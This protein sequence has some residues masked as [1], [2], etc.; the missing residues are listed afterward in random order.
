MSLV[1]C[2]GGDE[3]ITPV[4]AH[5][6]FVVNKALVPTNNNESR[7]YGLDLNG[8]GTPDNQLGMVLGTLAG[9]GFKIQDTLDVAVN[10]GNIILLLDFQAKDLTSA[11]A[12]GIQLY[13]GD[14]TTAM[15]AP[16]NGSAD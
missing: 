10:D 13:L 1:A 7:E 16:C 11:A 9:M 14:K 12:A 2:G 6:H 15:P 8:D 4:G 5:Y 3:V